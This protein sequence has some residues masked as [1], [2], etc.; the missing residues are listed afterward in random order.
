MLEEYSAY[1]VKKN[2]THFFIFLHKLQNSLEKS[3]R[4]FTSI[5]A[6]NFMLKLIHFAF[7][8]HFS[9]AFLQEISPGNFLFL[10]EI[11]NF[12]L[13]QILHDTSNIC[14]LLYKC[15]MSKTVTMKYFILIAINHRRCNKLP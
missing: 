4:N 10:H 15:C 8:S 12:T 3:C 7:T 9:P 1:K 2:K 11:P 13:R 5:S 6:E 14:F